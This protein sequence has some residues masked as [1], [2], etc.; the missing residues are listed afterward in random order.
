M[1]YLENLVL[2]L[3]VS[4]ISLGATAAIIPPTDDFTQAEADEAFPAGSATHTKRI[5][6]DAFSQASANMSFEREIDFKVGN[7]FFKR[8]WVTAPASTQAADGLG[9]L[10]NARSCQRCHLKDGRGHPPNGPDD[11]AVSM[12][13]RLSIPPQNEAE[14]RLLREHR[15]NNIADPVYGTQLQDFAIAGHKSEGQMRIDYQEIDVELEGGCS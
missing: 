10:Y 3:V 9:P 14:Q 15:V 7:G 13:L 5:N 2:C 12:F 11:N 6:R 4:A 8:L 1:S